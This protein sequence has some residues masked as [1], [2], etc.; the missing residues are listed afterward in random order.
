MLNEVQESTTK[1]EEVLKP[2]SVKP[3]AA[4]EIYTS[5]G[6]NEL[7]QTEYYIEDGIK[8]SKPKKGI[9]LISYLKASEASCD[10]ANIVLDM[11][12]VTFPL[13]T[14]RQMVLVVTLLLYH[15]ALMILVSYLL[16]WKVP[17]VDFLKKLER[18]FLTILQN[19]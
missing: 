14:L 2:W 6:K 5:V 1:K 8:K 12:A 9:D 4:R 19:S 7:P 16:E 15:I 3:R 11:K 10:L 17:L 18:Y 13:L